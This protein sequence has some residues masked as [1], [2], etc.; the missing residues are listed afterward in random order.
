MLAAGLSF[1][2]SMSG[3]ARLDDAPQQGALWSLSYA[4]HG[5]KCLLESRTH[6]RKAQ[7]AEA[8]LLPGDTTPT[9]RE[10]T[11][12]M[13]LTAETAVPSIFVG[14]GVFQGC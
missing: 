1:M 14:S 9:A 3:A 11:C 13:S 5:S 4:S 2:Q 7:A 8:K 6:D 12:P 10:D